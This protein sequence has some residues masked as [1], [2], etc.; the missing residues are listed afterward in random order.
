MIDNIMAFPVS[1]ESEPWQLGM[2]LRD[3]FAGHALAG[4]LASDSGSRVT[5]GRCA[6][7][8]YETAEAMLKA[9]GEL[10]SP[11]PVQADLLD[12]AV[13]AGLARHDLMEIALADILTQPV[14]KGFLSAAITEYLR[15]NSEAKND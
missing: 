7:L 3:Y 8:A 12:A 10:V 15:L 5:P 1:G 4:I 6:F 11:P 13:R 14:L 9:R 2:N